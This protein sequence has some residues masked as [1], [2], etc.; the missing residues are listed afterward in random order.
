MVRDINSV[1]VIGGGTMGSQIA[2]A[3][4]AAGRSVL[5][6]ELD[7][8][9]A[10]RAVERALATAQSDEEKAQLARHIQSGILKDRQGEIGSY[11]WLC[12]AIDED[13]QAKRTL[14]AQLE[15]LRR[16]G[17]VVSTNTS[18]ILLREITGGVPERLRRDIAVTHFFNPVRVMRLLEIVAGPETR[19]EARDTLAAFCRD[20]LG[21]GIVYAKD[22]VNFIGNRIGCFWILS[23]LHKAQPYLAAGLS[24]EKI[25]ALMGAPVGLPSTGLYG[26]VDL[27]G[28]DVMNYIGENLAVNL[29]AGDAG[30]AY[31]RFPAGEKALLARGQLGRKTG[32][33]FYRVR[34]AADGSKT[35][36]VFDVE[37]NGWHPAAAVELAPRH[38]R[39]DTL[40][41]SDDLEGRFA[42]D[43]MG[44]T[45]L[46]AAGLIPEISDDIVSIDRAMRWGF[47]WKKGPFELLD[48]VGPA[49][50]IERLRGAGQQV[51][52]MLAA[53]DSAHAATFYRDGEYL[54]LDGVY[55]SLPPE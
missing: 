47:A 28:L 25:D 21:K 54:G 48:E 22:T 8:A 10:R 20:A 14:F 24:M 11:D 16:D 43:L 44:G 19:A 38:A 35:K 55:R 26:L 1:L 27:I 33:G 23:G 36:E 34:K 53:L 42:W 52:R 18:G 15:P 17:S 31:A 29:P 37:A 4:A 6:L 13:L 9:L 51:P 12:E 49:R 46:Y 40:L 50:V 30:S 32:G 3:C 39:A 7:A 41:F 45:L 2:A 5:I